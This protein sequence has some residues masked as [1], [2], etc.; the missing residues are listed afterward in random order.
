MKRKAEKTWNRKRRRRRRRKR[1]IYHGGRSHDLIF[2]GRP[3][4][5]GY[6]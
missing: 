2:S 6:S 1:I 5:Y 4:Y 3:M